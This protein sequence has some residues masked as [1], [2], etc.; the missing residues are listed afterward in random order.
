MG[1]QLGEATHTE[2]GVRAQWG[3]SDSHTTTS[4][5]TDPAPPRAPAGSFCN[6]KLEVGR[7][8]GQGLDTHQSHS[9]GRLGLKP[10]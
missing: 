1:I 3:P 5:V 2:S 6:A 9:Q 10:T 7:M 4:A 8:E